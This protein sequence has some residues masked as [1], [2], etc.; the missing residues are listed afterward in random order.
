MPGPK[1]TGSRYRPHIFKAG[2]KLDASQVRDMRHAPRLRSPAE[3]AALQQS[4]SIKASSAWV[5]RER[6]ARAHG[7]KV[8]GY[9]P[10][11][12]IRRGA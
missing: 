10:S 8:K 12:D 9:K 7:S 2:V 11:D 5:K 6:A 3:I 1:R 4:A